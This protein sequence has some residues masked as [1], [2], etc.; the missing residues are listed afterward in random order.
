MQ[1]TAAP[2]VLKQAVE[3]RA[4]LDRL[5]PGQSGASVLDYLMGE[6]ATIAQD[7]RQRW[8]SSCIASLFQTIST[9][10]GACTADSLFIRLLPGTLSSVT[11]T[12]HTAITSIPRDRLDAT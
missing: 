5:N 4:S 10:A 9:N 12:S 1:R 2:R 8:W 6:H 3:F 7:K 11:T